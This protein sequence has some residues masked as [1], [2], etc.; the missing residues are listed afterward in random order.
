M[1]EM[2]F[3]D[4][5][6]SLWAENGQYYD[7]CLIPFTGLTGAENP[8]DSVSALERLRDFMEEVEKPFRGRMVTY[9]VFQYT[10]EYSL[11]LVNEICQKVKS[12]NFRYAVV[13]TADVE[14]STEEI[15]ESDLVLSLPRLK[16]LSPAE[17]QAYI[18]TQIQKLWQ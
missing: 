17:R 13:L 5:D 15:V 16:S 18:S 3:S 8:A 11:Q 6:L 12:I 7:T 14:L 1:G 2:K 10:G 4:F 9:P